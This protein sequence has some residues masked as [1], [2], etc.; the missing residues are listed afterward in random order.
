MAWQIL[1]INV[2]CWKRV[3]RPHTALKLLFGCLDHVE[4]QVPILHFF[5]KQKMILQN[6]D[7][8]F[9]F[10]FFRITTVGRIAI[11]DLSALQSIEYFHKTH[12]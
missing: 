4:A 3:L 1:K 8:I 10:S 7:T 6:V 2:A 5:V 9:F 11:A 12:V